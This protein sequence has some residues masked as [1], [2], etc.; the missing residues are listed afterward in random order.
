LALA[1]VLAAAAPA[2]A[3]EF[4]LK[5]LG[6]GEDLAAS[7]LAEGA[8]IVVVWATWSRGQGDVAERVEGLSR[9]WGTQARVVAVNFQEDRET[10]ER[11]LAD[12]RVPAP[13]FLDEDGEFSK[14]YV[15][16]QLPGLVVLKDGKAAYR[17]KFPDD[18]DGVIGPILR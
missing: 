6:G 10:V 1:L 7:D 2:A 8:T 9:R 11:Y 12:K 18:P 14:K 4:H 5:G 15:I 3:Q 17:G 16:T 13:V